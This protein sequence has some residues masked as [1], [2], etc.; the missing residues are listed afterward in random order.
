LPSK[1][2]ER[3]ARETLKFLYDNKQK[4]NEA[5]EKFVVSLYSQKETL[6]PN[7]IN[8]IK[9]NLYEKLMGTLGLGKVGLKH[10]FNKKNLR[11]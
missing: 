9:N 1:A 2:D 11:Y 10:D 3:R 5:D 7:Q 4:L 8:H 6:T